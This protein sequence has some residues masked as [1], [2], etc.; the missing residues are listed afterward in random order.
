MIGVFPESYPDELFFSRCARYHERIGYSTLAG[1]ARDLFGKGVFSMS[2]DLPANFAAF[3]ENLPPGHS[4]TV[5]SLIDA[6]TTLPFYAPFVTPERTQRAR[7]D[8]TCNGS[9]LAHLRLGILTIKNRPSSFWHCP[10]CVEEDR[11]RFGETYW[12][13]VHQL[14]GITICPVHETATVETNMHLFALRGRQ[15]LVTAEKTM[16]EFPKRQATDKDPHF[17]VKVRLARDAA[18]LLKN[19]NPAFSSSNKHRDRYVQLCFQNGVCTYSGKFDRAFFQAVNTHYSE[20]LLRDF[21]CYLGS[22]DSWAQ[23]LVRNHKSAQHPIYHLLLINFLGLTIAE[24]FALPD[25]QLPFGKGPWPCLNRVCQH[26]RRDVI[27]KYEPSFTQLT[28]LPRGLFRCRCGFAYSRIGPESSSEERYYPQ[29]Y[30]AFGEEWEAYVKNYFATGAHHL[31][32]LAAKL[33]LSTETLRV[34]LVSMGIWKPSANTRLTPRA[35]RSQ[36]IEHEER[37]LY[38]TTYLETVETLKSRTEIGKATRA[39]YVW[40]RK[41]DHEWWS[42]H[43]PP[44]RNPLKRKSWVDWAARDRQLA[45]AIPAEAVRIKTLPGYPTWASATAIA[46]NLKVLNL[47]SMNRERL[48]MAVRAIQQYAES[49]VDYAV[50]RIQ[51]AVSVYEEMGTIPTRPSL[52]AKAHVGTFMVKQ[53]KIIAALSAAIEYF[54]PNLLWSDNEAA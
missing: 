38:R 31:R 42:A 54:Q 53:E 36:T 51:W 7:I 10:D 16:G 43:T 45:L 49:N 15:G 41:H 27:E 9:A 19:A 1:S 29:N 35:A 30:I 47:V 3:V 6:N 12:H 37:E 28:R 13:R 24:F 8:M 18:W 25:T 4:L 44:R 34:K 26:F 23:R 40:L 20:E 21:G 48:P 2:I 5:D 22:T 11:Q 14:P 17:S 50:R 52:L 32:P 33:G 46:L 39:V